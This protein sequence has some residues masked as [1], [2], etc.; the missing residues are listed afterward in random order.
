[1]LGN[2][3]IVFEL[4]LEIAASPGSRSYDKKHVSNMELIRLTAG[5]G[6]IAPI[7]KY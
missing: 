5:L 4:D 2:V 6:F 7:I 1:V 3:L